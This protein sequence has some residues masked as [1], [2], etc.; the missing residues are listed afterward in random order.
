MKQKL[1]TEYEKQV[2]MSAAH[3]PDEKL[4]KAVLA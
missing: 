2:S 1:V 3:T 4:A